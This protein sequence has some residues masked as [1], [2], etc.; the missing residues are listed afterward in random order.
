MYMD[1]EIISLNVH[2]EPSQK[3]NEENRIL[4]KL[5]VLQLWLCQRYSKF[6]LFCPDVY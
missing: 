2:V 6:Y 3:R 4:Q 5:V 1:S